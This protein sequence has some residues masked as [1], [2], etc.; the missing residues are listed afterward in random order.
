MGRRLIQ[1]LMASVA[2]G[3]LMP[4]VAGAQ[5]SEIQ[6]LKAEQE[7]L[8]QR[9][10]RM[11]V[12]QRMPEQHQ[13][14]LLRQRIE[15]LESEQSKA[16][17]AKGDAKVPRFVESIND[18]IRLTLS[19]QVNRAALYANDGD[20]D[21]VFH[22]DNDN[23][24]TRLLFRG[25]GRFDEDLTVG[26][27]IEVQIESN[28]SFDVSIGGEP[29]GFNTVSFTE[30]KLE[31]FFDSKAFG[32]LWLGQ[33]DTAS[34][35]TSE[36]DLSGTAVV[37]LAS[38]AW[39][40]AGSIRFQEDGTTGPRVRD[41]F[42]DFDGLSRDDRIRYDTPS[43]EGF[44]F[45]TSHVDGSAWDAALTY[46][47]EISGIK[48]R[49]AIAYADA[50]NKNSR[51]LEQVNGSASVLFPFGLNFTVAAGQ[52]DLEKDGRDPS[53]YYAKVGYIFSP[54][55]IGSTAVSADWQLVEDRDRSG[56]EATTYGLALVQNIDRIATEAY[57]AARMYEL[58]RR[59]A[60]F[61]DIYAVMAGARVKF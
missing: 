16:A 19:G 48:T 10:E 21:Q 34:N 55:T 29:A 31:L 60:D 14:P 33:G 57:V 5:Q 37:S 42:S 25:V 2:L 17:A 23:S 20:E 3:V 35:G 24:S 36:S 54:L 7:A 28:S 1:C 15:R 30:R 41:V 38:G 22:V 26:T 18:D 9:I 40:M 61:D 32:R 44:K 4:S 56:D 13:D 49:A 58:D 12:Q 11:E 59:G 52:Q 6:R 43:F 45:S 27:Q 46:A 53:M 39:L 50:D 8:R 51:N 47:G